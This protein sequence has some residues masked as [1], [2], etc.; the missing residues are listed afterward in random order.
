V[1]TIEQHQVHALAVEGVDDRRPVARRQHHQPAR[2]QHLPQAQA[3]LVVGRRHEHVQGAC[4]R[5]ASARCP[6]PTCHGIAAMQ[7]LRWHAARRLASTSF[8][9][10]AP[11]T[12]PVVIVEA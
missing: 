9:R 1:R 7:P 8:A 10:A 6:R 5:R 2:A 4:R 12:P 11:A 3:P